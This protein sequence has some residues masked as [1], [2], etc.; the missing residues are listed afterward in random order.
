MKGGQRTD[1]RRDVATIMEHLGVDEYTIG[2]QDET[3]AIEAEK[4]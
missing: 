4:R 3:P 2:P 1:T